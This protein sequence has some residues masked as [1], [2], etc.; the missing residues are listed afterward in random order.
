MLYI[1]N[2]N[3]F[4]IYSF[5][6]TG[7]LSSTQGPKLKAFT[8]FCELFVSGFGVIPGISECLFLF[9]TKVQKLVGLCTMLSSA[10]EKYVW[11]TSFN[12]CLTKERKCLYSL[13]YVKSLH[14]FIVSKIHH[15]C[16]A[17]SWCFAAD[18]FH[19]YII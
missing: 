9:R 13:K 11:Q 6:F 1:Y 3:G 4:C 17:P 15:H 8:I 2:E 10:D 18:S 12:W 5:S 19:E 7:P 16:T 14:F